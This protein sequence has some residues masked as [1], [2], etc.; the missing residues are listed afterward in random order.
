MKKE[1]INRSKNSEKKEVKMMKKIGILFGIICLVMAAFSTGYAVSV[2]SQL[3]TNVVNLGSDNS[4]EYLINADGTTADNMGDTTVDVGDRLRAWFNVGTVENVSTSATNNIGVGAVNEWSGLIDITVATK[5][6]DGAGGF[7]YSF[8]PTPGLAAEL[9]GITGVPV[10]NLTGA[11]VGMFQDPAQNYSRISPPADD[12]PGTV[13]EE[14]LVGTAI[15]GTYFWTLGFSGAMGAPGVGEGWVANAVT[16]DITVIAGIPLPGNGGTVNIG[17]SLLDNNTSVVLEAIPCI[18]GGNVDFC[19][20]A[21]L[22]GTV[23]ATTPADIFD[24]IDI[25]FK[26]IAVP[27]PGIISLLGIGILGLGLFFRRKVR[28]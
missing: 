2:E 28:K 18:F 10:A 9:A 23:G 12:I 27:E 8:I 25:A 16:D 15:D 22:I 19:G 3:F 5:A 13:S 7:N 24:N 6:A 20:S 21:N 1:Q 17:L 26:P 4:A 11:M 14:A